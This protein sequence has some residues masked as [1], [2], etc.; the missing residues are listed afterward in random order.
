LILSTAVGT[1]SFRGFVDLVHILKSLL[2]AGLLR[3]D[4][5]LR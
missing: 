3:D 2:W 4:L 5:S 1:R